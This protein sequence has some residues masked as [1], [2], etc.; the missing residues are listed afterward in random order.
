MQTN[1]AFLSFRLIFKYS[2]GLVVFDFLEVSLI[3][4]GGRIQ[5]W[6]AVSP[7]VD[8]FRRNQSTASAFLITQFQQSVLP[9]NINLFNYV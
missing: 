8:F 2:V 1:L 5:F 7:T 6:T 4:V 9:F 3:I